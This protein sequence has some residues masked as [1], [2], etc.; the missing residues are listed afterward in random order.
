MNIRLTP[1]QERIISDELRS[2]RFHSADEVVATALAA[3]REK[4][5][6]STAGRNGRYDDAVREMFRFVEKNRTSLD[7]IS[8]KQLLHEGHRL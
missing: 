1:E 5:G 3:L 4:E 8:V 6:F 2:G 7:G